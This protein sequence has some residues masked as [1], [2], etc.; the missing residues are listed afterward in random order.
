MASG[1]VRTTDSTAGSAAD[2]AAPLDRLP[3]FVCVECSLTP[4]QGENPTDEWRVFSDGTNL[5]V[6]CPDCAE[7][8]FRSD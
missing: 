8:E 4:T 7:R 3:K 6:F 2:V 1:G 5:R